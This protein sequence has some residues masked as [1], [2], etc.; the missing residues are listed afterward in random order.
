MTLKAMLFDLDGTLL[1][2]DMRRDFLP[3]YFAAL[4]A[5]VADVVSPNALTAAVMRGSD[6]I[7][8]ND[9]SRTNLEAFAEVFYPL[10]GHAREAME[11]RF[12]DFYENVFPSLQ[13]YARRKPEARRAMQAAF[14]RGCDVVIA[15]NPHFPAIATQHR[16]AWAG[17]DDFNFRK[18]TAYENSS[19]AKPNLG[20]YREILDELGRAPE[21]ALMIGDEAMDMVAGHLGCPT[22]LVASAATHLE[23]IDPPPTYQ[24]ALTDLITLLADS[25]I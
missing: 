13:K 3:P 22:F 18:V 12:M 20:Y 7:S 10:I 11:P 5:H 24:G 8:N 6:A 17:I 21:E 1:D 2:Y 15:T 4:A 19:F 23:E 9:G 25:K 16:L 14:D